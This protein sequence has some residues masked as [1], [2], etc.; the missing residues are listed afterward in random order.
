MVRVAL[1]Q[2]SEQQALHFSERMIYAI[3]NVSLGLKNYKQI[4]YRNINAKPNRS[5]IA[6]NNQLPA[7]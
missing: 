2:S 4:A 3:I 1:L 6:V 7:W 5:M